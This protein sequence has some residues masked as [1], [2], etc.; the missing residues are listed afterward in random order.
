MA[1]QILDLV[2]GAAATDLNT[3]FNLMDGMTYT[4]EVVAG[5]GAELADAADGADVPESGHILFRAQ[6]RPIVP[7]AGET[8]YLWS[9][10]GARVVLSAGF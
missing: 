1:T 4:V 3:A 7:Q 6:P 8:M 2:A 9:A 10:D 5:I